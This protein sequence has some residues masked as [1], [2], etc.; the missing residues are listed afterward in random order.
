MKKNYRKI[1]FFSLIKT[2]TVEINKKIITVE[3]KINV[4]REMNIILF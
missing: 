1:T 2:I 3:G 4:L